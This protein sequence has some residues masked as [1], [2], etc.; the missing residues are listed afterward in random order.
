M[1]LPG[2]ELLYKVTKGHQQCANWQGI[3]TS[4]QW[5]EVNASCAI[6]QISPLVYEVRAYM[7][8]KDHI[9]L[10]RHVVTVLDWTAISQGFKSR[11][12]HSGQ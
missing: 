5:S 7:T 12:S 1:A 2:V 6:S 8:A 11:L 10:C 3:T 9:C 4:Y